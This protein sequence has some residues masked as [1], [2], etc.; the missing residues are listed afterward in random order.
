[1]KLVSADIEN[2]RSIKK[3]SIHFNEITAIVGE[4]NAGKSAVLRALNSFFNYEFKRLFLSTP[5]IDMMLER[6]QRSL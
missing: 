5:L 4:N 3:C 6:Y 2:F 1:M